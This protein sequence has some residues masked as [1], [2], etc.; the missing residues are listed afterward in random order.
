MHLCAWTTERARD[1]RARA[2]N[3]DALLTQARPSATLAPMTTAL[4]E[5]DRQRWVNRAVLLSWL[6]IA[7]NSVEAVVSMAFGWSH[8]SVA[9][10]GFGVDA[11][12]EVASASVVL[13][14][15]KGETAD[16]LSAASVERERRA[17]LVIGALFLVLASGTLA[18]AAIQLATGGAPLT[19]L[20]G[21]VMGATSLALMG[22]LWHA[23][24]TAAAALDSATVA[25]DAACSLACIHLSVVLL[26]G[27]A[28][29]ALSPT[30]WWADSAAAIALAILIAR[31]GLQTIRAARSKTFSGGCGCS[32]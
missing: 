22:F 24:R 32:H 29:Y 13:W 28:L 10:F 26:A 27:S 21:V 16:A 5:P 3:G 7:W 25:S 2:S 31:E 14:R 20:P 9:L 30:L 18:G 6:T 15:F 1:P 4:A 12:V 8:E 11:L 17:A 19:T 23:K